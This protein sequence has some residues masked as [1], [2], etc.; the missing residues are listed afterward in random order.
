MDNNTVWLETSDKQL[1]NLS[2]VMRLYFMT[3]VKEVLLKVELP[4]NAHLTIGECSST[5]VAVKV[6]RKISNMTKIGTKCIDI[7]ML[8]EQAEEESR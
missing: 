5:I 1:I 7:R 3:K 6:I 4:D 2:Y 8:I